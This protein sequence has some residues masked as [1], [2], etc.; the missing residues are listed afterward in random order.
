MADL[1]KE[2]CYDGKNSRPRIRKVSHYERIPLVEQKDLGNYENVWVWSDTHFGHNNIIKY[3]DRPYEDLDAMDRSLIANY[4]C[5]VGPDDLCIWVG[6]VAFKG[7]EKANEILDALNGN[8]ILVVGNHDINKGKVKNMNFNEI[9]LLYTI[10]DSIA[11]LLF[12]HFPFETI[13]QPWINIHGHIH[14]SHELGSMQHINVS[15]EVIGYKPMHLDEIKRT[16]R[17]RAISMEA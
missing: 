13:P 9:H 8:K 10:E 16:A 2:V 5:T 12:T 14:N 17:T 6:D 7:A 15:V 4:N 1:R 11:P 3:C